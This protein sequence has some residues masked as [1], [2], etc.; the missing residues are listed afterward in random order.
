MKT[1]LY[2]K[3]QYSPLAIGLIMVLSCTSVFGDENA[4]I[5]NS[6]SENKL[7]VGLLK[8][9]QTLNERVKDLE[10][11]VLNKPSGSDAENSYMPGWYMYP[12]EKQAKLWFKKYMVDD[13]SYKDGLIIHSNMVTCSSDIN[14]LLK[15]KIPSA[16]VEEKSR[17]YVINVGAS[18]DT[19]QAYTSIACSDK[20]GGFPEIEAQ[21]HYHSYGFMSYRNISIKSGHSWNSSV[22]YCPSINQEDEQYIY[23][24]FAANASGTGLPAQTLKGGSGFVTLSTLIGYW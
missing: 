2:L 6:Y 9:I 10:E 7:S 22:L 1:T 20:N 4:P 21:E 8:Q 3:S 19:L 16:I 18:A 14:C 15:Y 23:I 13:G 24:R 12:A 17:G 5:E 11:H